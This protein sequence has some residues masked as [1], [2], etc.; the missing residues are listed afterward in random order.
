MNNGFPSAANKRPRKLYSDDNFEEDGNKQDN[1]G[2]AQNDGSVRLHT[3]INSCQDVI[4]DI[5]EAG[6]IDYFDMPHDDDYYDFMSQRQKYL[7]AYCCM[8][9]D[10][11]L[12]FALDEE[13][14][15]R[16]LRL[17]FNDSLSKDHKV[18]QVRELSRF[19]LNS[20]LNEIGCP[21]NFHELYADRIWSGN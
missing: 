2:V 1:F 8:V 15:G 4:Y 16:H 10:Y 19:L 7:A 6:T 17:T 21:H 12:N 14:I 5:L 18:L 20:F 3:F 9:S 11:G 13:V